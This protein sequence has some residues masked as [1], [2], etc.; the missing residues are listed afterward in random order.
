MRSM[1]PSACTSAAASEPPSTA[2]HTTTSRL[3]RRASVG[4]EGEREERTDHVL[5]EMRLV[6]EPGRVDPLRERG[7]P[8]EAVARPQV[9]LVVP[10]PEG[11]PR[12]RG[13]A[14]L[15]APRSAAA[16]R[17]DRSSCRPRL[18]LLDCTTAH[19]GTLG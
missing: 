17:R 2:V 6:P 9:P 14:T 19:F 16:A 13:G 18:A 1:C 5:E 8:D 10:R 3:A 11:C 12:G 7:R 15:Q 4:E